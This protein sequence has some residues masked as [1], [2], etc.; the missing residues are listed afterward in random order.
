MLWRK[1]KLLQL[2]EIEKYTNAFYTLE[3][4]YSWKQ[5]L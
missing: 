1:E 5:G 3:E 4:Y 2:L